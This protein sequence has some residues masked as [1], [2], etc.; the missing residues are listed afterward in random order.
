MITMVSMCG[1]ALIFARGNCCRLRHHILIT[2][3][4]IVPRNAVYIQIERRFARR[5]ERRQTDSLVLLFGRRVCLT[6]WC[7]RWL[8]LQISSG[9]TC[10]RR[11]LF[12]FICNFDRASERCRCRML[13]MRTVVGTFIIRTGICYV[14]GIAQ[15]LHLFVK[16]VLT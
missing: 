12:L 14:S 8:L 4:T 3:I 11:L 2:I 6:N 10:N 5:C 1:I 15:T 7:Y 16:E 13:R 9:R